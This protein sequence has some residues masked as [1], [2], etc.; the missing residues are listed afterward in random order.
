MF[1]ELEDGYRIDY[2]GLLVATGTDTV[3]KNIPGLKE[4]E[5]LLYLDNLND[6]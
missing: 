3:H 6:H 2:D 1:I 4:A 5:N